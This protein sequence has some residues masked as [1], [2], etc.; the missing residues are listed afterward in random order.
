MLAALLALSGCGEEEAGS[1]VITGPGYTFLA[2]GDWELEQKPRTLAVTRVDGV[3]TVAVSSFRLARRF[4]PALWPAAVRELDRVAGQ[5]ADRLSP[6]AEISPGRTRIV[7][8]RRARVYDIRYERAERQLVERVGFV[9]DGRREFQ[10]L[11]RWSVEQ[12][13]VGMEACGQLFRSFRLRPS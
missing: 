10:L 3:E 5:L 9:L 4:R 2:P 6:A 7:A 1:R 13:A 12:A 8:G 11:C